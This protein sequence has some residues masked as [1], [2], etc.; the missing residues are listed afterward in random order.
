[1]DDLDA[2]LELEG[3]GGWEEEDEE[4]GE[5]SRETKERVRWSAGPRVCA[6]AAAAPCA[7]P[8]RSLVLPRPACLQPGS[9]TVASRG[10]A[11]M[12]AC[13]P[14]LLTRTHRQS[15]PL[16][17]KQKITPVQPLLLCP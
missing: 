4:N 2:L 9:S 14:L 10:S 17:K 15:L 3:D 8:G 7:S 12:R 13:N 11:M 6:G 5:K 1:M 16:K